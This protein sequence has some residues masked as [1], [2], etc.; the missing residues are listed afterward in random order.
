V[1]GPL[2]VRLALTGLAG[3]GAYLTILFQA[4][5]L[6]RSEREAVSAWWQRFIPRVAAAG[7]SGS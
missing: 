3:G 7:E 6:D 1:P 2:L 4:G 5:L